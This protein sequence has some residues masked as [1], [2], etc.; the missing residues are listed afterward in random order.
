[1]DAEELVLDGNALSGLLS[2]MLSVEATTVV[3]RCAACGAEERVAETAVHMNCPGVVVRCHGCSAVLMRFA[4]IRGR[5]VAD[6]H[7][8]GRLTL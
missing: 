4:H 2:E 3:V 1:M 8:V 6:L 5:L 7:G